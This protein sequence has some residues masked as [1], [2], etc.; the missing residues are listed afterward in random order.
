MTTLKEV[1]AVAELQCF[2]VTLFPHLLVESAKTKEDS[3]PLPIARGEYSYLNL[4]P[5][6]DR[7]Q[8]LSQSDPLGGKSFDAELDFTQ[9]D[10]VEN[11]GKVLDQDVQKDEACRK[12]LAFALQFFIDAE[13]KGRGVIEGLMRQ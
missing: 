13:D 2:G 8:G 1:R 12:R 4:G 5:T 6:P 3:L 11:D 9:T 7:L 10:Y